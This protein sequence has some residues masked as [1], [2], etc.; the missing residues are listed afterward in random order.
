[1]TRST[2]INRTIQLPRWAADIVA[3]SPQSGDGFHFWLF[4]AARA[5]WKCGRHKDEICAV[6]ENA[7][8][9]CGRCVQPREIQSAI[10]NSRL[11]ILRGPTLG[12]RSWPTINAE[13]REAIIADGDGLIGMWETSPVRFEDNEQHTE[14]IIDR[15]FSANPLLCCGRS[16]SEFDTKPREQ[17]RG[18]LSALQ[19]IVP[20]A[21]SAIAG[22]TQDGRESKHALSNTGPRR[23]LVVEFDTGTP[24]DHASLILHLAKRAPLALGMHSG[25]KSMHGWFYCDGQPESRLELFMRYAVSLGADRATWTR[26]QFVRMP[27]GKRDSGMRQTVY[28]FNPGVIQ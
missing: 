28:F 4:R 6:L 15:L 10:E 11:L 7:A 13:Q 2:T 26:S 9:A 21:M 1:M 23:F 5:L 25:G 17:W 24:D 8:A 16:N 14:S 19:F 27:D 20:S 12:C 22:V 3:N 18:E